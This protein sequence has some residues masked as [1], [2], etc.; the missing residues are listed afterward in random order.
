ME[1]ED[2][3][4]WKMRTPGRG[5][6]VERASAGHGAPGPRDDARGRDAPGPARAGP[7][8]SGHVAAV[9]GPQPL[10]LWG[11]SPGFAYT[12]LALWSL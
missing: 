8:A 2:G 1:H 10:R 3:D 4:E 9:A 5:R 7:S 6:T 11:V 12:A